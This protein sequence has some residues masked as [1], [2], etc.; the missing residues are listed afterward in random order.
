MSSALCADLSN[1]N[2][3]FD[4]VAYRNSGHLIVA[5]KAT[6]G[7][8]FSDGKHHGWAKAAHDHKIAVIHYHFARPDRGTS[9]AEEAAHFLGFMHDYLGPHD[10]VCYDG[11]RAANGAFGLDVGHC[12]EF[13]QHIQHHTTFHTLLYASASQLANAGPALVGSR[14]RDWDANYSTQ[15][16]T[17]APGH[18]LVLRQ[19]TDG[20]VGPGPH[21][22]PG[23]GQCDVNLMHG[24]VLASVFKYANADKHHK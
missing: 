14:K 8:F 5:L 7:T 23:C 4:P 24:S 6:E 20:F 10:Y 2:S 13:D 21:S 11:E 3:F 19:F 22:L 15:P 17:H 1:N 12:R 9:G 18:E 16:D